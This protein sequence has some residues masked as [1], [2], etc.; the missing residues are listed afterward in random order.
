[1]LL[2]CFFPRELRHFARTRKVL[3]SRA[4]LSGASRV[5]TGDLLLAKLADAIQLP[6]RR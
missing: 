3:V 6:H 4:F 5:R 2:P 1:V